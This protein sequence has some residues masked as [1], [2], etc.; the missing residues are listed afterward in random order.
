MLLKAASTMWQKCVAVD[1]G[2]DVAV[3]G[4]EESAGQGLWKRLWKGPRRAA[5]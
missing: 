2:L 4:G 3:E 1:K 5:V